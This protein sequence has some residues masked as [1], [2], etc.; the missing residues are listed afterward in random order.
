MVNNIANVSEPIR[1]HY[2]KRTRDSYS[3]EHSHIW[4]QF[5]LY[6]FFIDF[7]CHRSAAQIV[8]QR[9]TRRGRISITKIRIY[10]ISNLLTK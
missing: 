1:W 6:I 4:M 3:I 8:P 7:R 5:F 2:T 9:S 10:S